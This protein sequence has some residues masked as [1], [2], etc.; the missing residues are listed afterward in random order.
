MNLPHSSY[1]DV[2]N[3]LRSRRPLQIMLAGKTAMLFESGI[4]AQEIKGINLN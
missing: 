2:L 3:T 1:S 4:P